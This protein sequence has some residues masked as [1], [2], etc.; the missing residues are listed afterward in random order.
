MGSDKV[1]TFRDLLV[2]QKAHHLLLLIYKAT[3]NFPPTEKYII[4]SQLQR[5]MLSVPTN[6]VEGYHR[7]STKDYLHFLNISFSSLEEVKYHLF[8]SK[9]L[10]YLSQIQYEEFMNLAEEVSRMLHGLQ[11]SLASKI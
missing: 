1:K 9:D 10:N 5:A 4:T 3:Q 7:K 6:I 11:K 2:W 8:V